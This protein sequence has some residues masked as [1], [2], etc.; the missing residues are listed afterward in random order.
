MGTSVCAGAGGGGGGGGGAPR[1]GALTG[2]LKTGVGAALGVGLGVGLGTVEGAA[3]A[4]TLDCP[5]SGRAVGMG[6]DAEG[7]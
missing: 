3:A 6:L 2:V 7:F 5:G 4:E 1:E